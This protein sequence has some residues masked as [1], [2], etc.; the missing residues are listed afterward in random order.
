[1]C[2]EINF[3]NFKAATLDICEELKVKNC[4]LTFNIYFL[5]HNKCKK[6]I[7]FFFFFFCVKSSNGVGP[8]TLKTKASARAL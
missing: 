3:L 6:C 8:G 1:M 5:T 4:F 2:Q 7:F